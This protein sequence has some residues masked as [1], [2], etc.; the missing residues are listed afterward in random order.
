MLIP[1]M[2]KVPPL[3]KNEERARK[4]TRASIS[5]ERAP[6]PALQDHRAL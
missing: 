6:W 3:G 2:R 1:T 4:V 5:S